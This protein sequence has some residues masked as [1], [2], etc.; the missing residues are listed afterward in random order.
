MSRGALLTILLFGFGV[1]LFVGILLYVGVDDIADALR[2][3]DLKYLVPVV[4]LIFIEA[5]I[6]TFRWQYII[7]SLGEKIHF[8]GLFPIWLAGNA[9][10]YLSPVVYVG[11]EGFRIFLLKQQHL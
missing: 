8:K 4:V 11:G 6:S 5:S 1:A 10:N 7:N 9:F 3:L 2:Q